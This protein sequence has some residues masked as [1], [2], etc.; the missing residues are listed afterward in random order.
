MVAAVG[1]HRVPV[2]LDD[3]E[4]CDR[5]RGWAVVMAF[6]TSV[7]VAYAS[8]LVAFAIE[9][10]FD[11]R[12]VVGCL[13]S[14]GNR[15]VMQMDSDQGF[16]VDQAAYFFSIGRFPQLSFWT[17]NSAPECEGITVGSKVE[18][19]IGGRRMKCRVC[20]GVVHI[21]LEKCW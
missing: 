13:V 3:N 1:D 2:E 18:D 4:I 12:V 5:R 17:A 11:L 6:V 21:P 8:G 20:T 19:W 9:F 7:C 14:F 15:L 10:L 16:A